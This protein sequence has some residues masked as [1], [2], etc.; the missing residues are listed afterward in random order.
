[1]E[2]DLVYEYA[3]LAEKNL[4]SAY[5]HGSG[6][7]EPAEDGGDANG[8][9]SDGNGGNQAPGP[10]GMICEFPRPL[11]QRYK[12]FDSCSRSAA[13]CDKL[14]GCNCASCMN[15]LGFVTGLLEELKQTMCLDLDHIHVTGMS[16]GAIFTYT[17]PHHLGHQI[18]S[19]VPAA[20]SNFLGYNGE[21]ESPV[22]VMDIRGF[23]DSYVPANA[24][25]GLRQGTG[26]SVLSTDYFWYTPVSN[27]TAVYGRAVECEGTDTGAAQALAY[28]PYPTK[29]DGEQSFSCHRPHGRCKKGEVVQCQGAFGHTWPLHEKHPLMFA[30]LA[31]QFFEQTPKV[32]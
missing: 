22:S 25:N 20:G 1:M 21:L 32:Q 6:P 18:A 4:V 31:V 17:L 26:G 29:W 10:D 19:I 14:R 16:A 27:L 24:S 12:C 13:G 5:L 2:Q 8:W 28:N 9:N 30:E 11:F 7:G 23:S 3:N 15:D